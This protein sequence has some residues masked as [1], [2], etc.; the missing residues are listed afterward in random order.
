MLMGHEPQ[1]REDDEASQEARPRV[2][3]SEEQAVSESS[4]TCY[5]QVYKHM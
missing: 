4:G 3:A 5:L 2:D 1:D